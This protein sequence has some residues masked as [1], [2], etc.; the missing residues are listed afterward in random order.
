MNQQSENKVQG[1]ETIILTEARPTL[2][3][4]RQREI[5]KQACAPRM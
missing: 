1:K 4:K 2:A 3:N 5:Q